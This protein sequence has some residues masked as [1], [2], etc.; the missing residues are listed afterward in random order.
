MC[1]FVGLFN[2]S[3]MPFGR[4]NQT[5]FD[6]SWF[7]INSIEFR[8][9]NSIIAGSAG[10]VKS[11]LRNYAQDEP[12]SGFQQSSNL[13]TPSQPQSHGKSVESTAKPAFY[14]CSR[15][16][17]HSFAEG[18]Q[19]EYEKMLVKQESSFTGIAI[20]NGENETVLGP[21]F[22][23]DRRFCINNERFPHY[24]AA[25]I[26]RNFPLQNL[27]NSFLIREE[28]KEKK[29]ETTLVDG[30]FQRKEAS[31]GVKPN[32]ENKSNYFVQLHKYLAVYQ[33]N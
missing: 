10:N 4:Q 14:D 24:P 16:G 2:S 28:E 6:Q 23:M 22:P 11:H 21:A 7:P 27:E 15:S 20:N 5:F 33:S 31:R 32:C 1:L 12:A 13:P 29:V 18:V 30:N 26:T 3:N 19:P 8:R 17:L 25:T 9:Q